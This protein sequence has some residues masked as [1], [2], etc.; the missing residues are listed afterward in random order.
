MAHLVFQ[1]LQCFSLDKAGENGL[2]YSKYVEWVQNLWVKSDLLQQVQQYGNYLLL[3]LKLKSYIPTIHLQNRW[4][5]YL[6]L[7]PGFIVEFDSPVLRD[8]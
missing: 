1:N 5:N 7:I 4:A 6:Q 3:K 8:F 2:N